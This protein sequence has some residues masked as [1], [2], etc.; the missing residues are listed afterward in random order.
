MPLANLKK[1][2]HSIY[3]EKL[4][5]TLYDTL[6]LASTQLQYRFFA[7]AEGQGAPP[8][9]RSQTN[10]TANGQIPTGQRLTIHRLKAFYKSAAS[11]TKS[12][13]ELLHN[14]LFNATFEVN[15]PGKDSLII[16]P[17]AEL[18]G[19]TTMISATANLL[20]AVPLLF[21]RFHGIY[22]LNKKIVLAEQTQF[23]VI[24]NCYQGTPDVG[25]DESLLRIGLN[26]ILER[27]S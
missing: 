1:G 20:V 18:F 23:S 17:L 11:Y 16:I 6:P 7:Q 25:L 15:I 19:I 8:K 14:F 26:G 24:I 4:D 21:P 2:T 3:G 12:E 22:P 10:A 9:D 13:I 5:Y 27:R